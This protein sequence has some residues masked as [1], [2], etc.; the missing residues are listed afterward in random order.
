MSNRLS[1]AAPTL[2]AL[3]AMSGC[4]DQ[5]LSPSTD[6]RAS[7]PPVQAAAHGS[8]GDRAA[9]QQILNTLDQAWTAGDP[10]A[11]AARYAGAEWVGPNGTVLTDPG[12]ITGL[13]TFVFSVV[14]P[15]TTRQS[16]IRNLTFLTGTI[17][18]LNIDARVTGFASLAPGQVPWQPGIVRALEKNVLIKRGGEWQI[19][20]HQQTIAAP[21]T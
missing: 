2:L 1:R 20:Q 12:A 15:G 19:V 11:Y 10:V 5:P 9:I 13:Y 17:A 21:G 6:E 3:V 18:V 8:P 14:F 16:T 7:S 4:S